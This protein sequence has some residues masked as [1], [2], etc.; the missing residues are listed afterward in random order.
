[1]IIEGNETNAKVV[2]EHYSWGWR[3]GA[4]GVR[5]CYSESWYVS[6][7]L[8][9]VCSSRKYPYP[10]GGGGATEILRGGGFKKG[11]TS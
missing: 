3:F 4:R 10:H 11:A 1:M 6:H 5:Y 2:S 9:S 8:S 7:T